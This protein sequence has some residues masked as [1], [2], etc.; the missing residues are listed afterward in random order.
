MSGSTQLRAG[1]I[2]AGVFGRLHAQKYAKAPGVRL[3]GIADAHGERAVD[4]AHAHGVGAFTRIDDLLAE[5]DVVS[6]ATPAVTHALVAKRCLDA[7]KH[8]Y[9]E[10]PIAVRE[11]DADELVALAERQGC[12]LHIGHQERLVLAATGLLERKAA[13]IVIE[14]VRAGPFSGR[15]TDVSVVLDLMIHDIDMVQLLAQSAVTAIKASERA[16]PGGHSD[17]VEAE[18]SLQSG[19]RVRLMAS[20]DSKE[21]RRT[22]RVVYPDGEVVID[23]LSRTVKNSTPDT[24][25]EL[26]SNGVP[27][28]PDLADPLGA[29]VARFLATVRGEGAPLLMPTE[30]RA[31]LVTANQI[32]AAAA[33]RQAAQGKLIPA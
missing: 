15:A 1:V 29:S 20:R 4:A 9:L 17:E 12:V 33:G 31:A 24:L 26:F 27:V 16:G 8:V 19:C 28:S 22:M 30:A 13:P 11:E 3:I 32:L 23:F 5:V 14:S 10:K 2:G 18:L 7:A 25:P 21:R 6:V